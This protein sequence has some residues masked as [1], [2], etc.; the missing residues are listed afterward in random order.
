MHELSLAG[1]LV[2]LVE[3]HARR[4]AM[5]RVHRVFV[6]LG[7]L[8]AVEPEALRT[9]F[10]FARMG[11]CAQAE[12]ELDLVPASAHCP[13]CAGTTQVSSR[14]DA[15]PA[16]GGTRLAISG[17]DQMRLTHLEGS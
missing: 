11:A 3:E 17:G 8:A 13:D 4:N 16:C 1:G 2:D 14:F 10:S 5:P 15:C 9:A 7:A 12:L 6:E